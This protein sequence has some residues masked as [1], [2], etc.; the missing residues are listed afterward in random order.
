M[1]GAGETAEVE[2]RVAILEAS[3]ESTS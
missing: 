2:E 3:I 1:G